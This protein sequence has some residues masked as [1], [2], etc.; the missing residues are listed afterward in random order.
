MAIRN[1]VT[2]INFIKFT[3]NMKKIFTLF[4]VFALALA[5]N[6]QLPALMSASFDKETNIISVELDNGAT[7]ITSFKFIVRLPEG[8]SVAS[9]YDED[10]EEYIEQILKVSKRVPKSKTFSVM[11]TQGDKA[12]AKSIVCYGGDP[13]KNS[14]Q[15][16]TLVTIQV[17]GTLAGTVKFTEAQ[18][19]MDGVETNLADFT[20][21]FPTAINGISADE[22]KSGVIYNM[23]GQRVS[24]ATK[25]IFVVDGKKVAV[26]K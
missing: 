9:V 10:E 4:A 7:T 5:A 23:A 18:V 21:E 22:T 11:D 6:A 16:K 24:K 15:T 19:M 20:Y 12:G 25:G 8:V 17:T 26:S 13:V 14:D 1:R 2:I 3:K